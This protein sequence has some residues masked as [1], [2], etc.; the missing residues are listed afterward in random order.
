VVIIAKNK[1]LL[2]KTFCAPVLPLFIEIQPKFGHKFFQPFFFSAAP[3]ELFGRNFCHLATL[4]NIRRF[5]GQDIQDDEGWEAVYDTGTTRKFS[6]DSQTATD[7]ALAQEQSTIYVNRP[8]KMG[9]TGG[10]HYTGM[11]KN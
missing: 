3:F 5:I 4:N 8:N 1:E 6:T 10:K 7:A 9:Q 2:L 11:A